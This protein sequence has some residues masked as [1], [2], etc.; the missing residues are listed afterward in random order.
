MRSILARVAAVVCFVLVVTLVGL[1]T[2][3]ALAPPAGADAIAAMTADATVT[4]TSDRYLAFDPGDADVGFILYPG[5]RVRP[6]AYAP[7]ARILAEAG[8]LVAIPDMPLRLALLAPGRADTV[9][10]AHPDVEHWVVGGHSLGGTAAANWAAFAEVSGVV[11]WASYPGPGT[12]LSGRSDLRTLTVA[13]SA[14]GLVTADDL[15][16]TRHRLGPDHTEIV[17]EGGN[18]AQFGDYGP[19]RGDGE[20]SISAAIQWSQVANATLRLLDTVAA[21][22]ALTPPGTS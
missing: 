17:V 19:Q 13:A 14:D 7:V 15:A 21:G 11:F 22:R 9:I 8:Y 4:V 18:H 3:A 12:D 5:A 20:A 2:W 10:A 1:V 6:E 16:D